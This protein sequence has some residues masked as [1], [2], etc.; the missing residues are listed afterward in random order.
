MA[1][2]S[3]VFV[4]SILLCHLTYKYTVFR[5]WFLYFAVGLFSAALFFKITYA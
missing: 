4:T 1:V 5:H 2:A 3:M